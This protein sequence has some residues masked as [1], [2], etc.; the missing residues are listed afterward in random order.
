VKKS[1]GWGFQPQQIDV[2]RLEAPATFRF[3]ERFSLL[4]AATAFAV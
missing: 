3:R 1:R 2:M 4:A